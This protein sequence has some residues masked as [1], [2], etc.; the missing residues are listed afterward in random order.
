MKKLVFVRRISQI[1]FLLI[2][3]SILWAT[4]Y[5]LKSLL[6]AEAFFKFDPLIM[7]LTSVSERIIPSG[8]VFSIVMVLLTL[9]LGRF[10]CGWVC[11]LGTMIDMAGAI[12][13]KRSVDT[14]LN[15]KIYRLKFMIL[16]G[17]AL[18]ALLGM[19]VVAWVFDPT[20]IIS[21]FVSLNFIPAITFIVDRF[22]ILMIKTFNL[23]GA[24]LD[25][26]HYLTTSFLGFKMYYF[27]HSFII[28]SVPVLI[29][30]MTWWIEVL[31]PCLLPAWRFV[32]GVCAIRMVRAHCY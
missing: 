16:L 14:R 31:V 1:F 8:L 10:F 20:V 13:K 7:F 21:R 22:F 17:V 2:F 24:L 29:C 30:G 11:P 3:I 32:C 15:R 12:R 9:I 4:T 26:Y 18:F 27:P 5:P 25:I 19:Q 6:P 23:R 28:L